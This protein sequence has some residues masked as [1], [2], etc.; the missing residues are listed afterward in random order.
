MLPATGVVARDLVAALGAAEL[1][2]ERGTAVGFEDDREK[3]YVVAAV[4]AADVVGAD[5]PVAVEA[6]CVEAPE[7]EAA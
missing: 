5:E 7:D 1:I 3:L 2:E 6:L 4:E